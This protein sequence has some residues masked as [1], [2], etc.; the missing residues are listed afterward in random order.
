MY[1]IENFIFCLDIKTVIITN[2]I[3][4]WVS[5]TFHKNLQY[6]KAKTHKI[7]R[8][9]NNVLENRLRILGKIFRIWT[10]KQGVSN[11]AKTWGRRNLHTPSRISTFRDSEFT[12]VIS[13]S[14]ISRHNSNWI[15]EVSLFISYF[16]NRMKIR[17][18]FA[19]VFYWFLSKENFWKNFLFFTFRTV[20][21]YN[22]GYYQSS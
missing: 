10:H 20:L 18:T 4:K 12:Q 14:I 16:C 8:F 22:S 15:I 2:Q 17:V 6:I 9:W 21:Y 19:I 1:Y 11:M 3:I 13:W 7:L 5:Q